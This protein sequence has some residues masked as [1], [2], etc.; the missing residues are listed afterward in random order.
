MLVYGVILCVLIT[1]GQ[2]VSIATAEDNTEFIAAIIVL[3]IW[4]PYLPLLLLKYQAL[5]N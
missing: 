3:L 1:I 2:F 5:L 4:I